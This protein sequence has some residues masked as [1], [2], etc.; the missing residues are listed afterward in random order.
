[1]NSDI[2]GAISNQRQPDFRGT[3]IADGLV[4][5]VKESPIE[6]HALFLSKEVMTLSIKENL[7]SAKQIVSCVRCLF[8][9]VLVQTQTPLELLHKPSRHFH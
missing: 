5:L 4:E 1:M 9:F 7:P 3:H 6:K 2:E 8:P